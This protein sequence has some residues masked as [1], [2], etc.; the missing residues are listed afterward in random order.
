MNNNTKS[1]ELIYVILNFGMGSRVYKYARELGIKR[2]MIILGKG[3]VKSPLLEFLGITDVRKE[4]ILMVCESSKINEIVP[5]IVDTFH[6]D[7]P[8]KG[9]LFTIPIKD[10]YDLQNNGKKYVS[11]EVKT[12]GGVKNTMYDAIFV[13]VDKG[14]AEFVVEAANEAGAKGG[15]IIH[16]RGAGEYEIEKIFS[17]EIEPE[18]DIVLIIVKEELTE[19]VVNSIRDK[20]DI[21]KE[22]AGIIFVQE[23]DQ[24]YGLI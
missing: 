13:V 16:A 14:K 17:M 22:G 20:L 15:T 12:N 24:A 9:I 5:K 18:K 19:A 11:A 1:Y 23:V 7:K 21:E 2:G 8:N 10:F 6:I 4:I 3:T